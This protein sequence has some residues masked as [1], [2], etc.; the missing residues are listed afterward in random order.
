MDQRKSE[1]QEKEE[2]F[3]TNF[4]NTSVF[5]FSKTIPPTR[6]TPPPN[7]TFM[8]HKVRKVSDPE[9]AILS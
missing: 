8:L 6:S 5:N 4:F 3:P 2:K 7:K 9:I 1:I